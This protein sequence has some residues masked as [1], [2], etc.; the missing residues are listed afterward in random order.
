MVVSHFRVAESLSKDAGRG[1]VRLD[2]N[3]LERLGLEVGDVVAIVGKKKALA[4]VMPAFPDD[5]GSNSVQMDGILR[6]NTGVGLGE[7]VS[8]EKLSCSPA[9]LVSL[10]PALPKRFTAKEK[11]A[12]FLG[13]LLEG[14]PLLPNSLV[15]VNLLGA[16]R[17][18][19]VL[20]TDP[21][22]AVIVTAE[23]EIR[24]VGQGAGKGIK[25]SYEDIGGL[26]LEIQRVREMVELPLRY[27]ELFERLGIDAPKGILLHGPPGTGKT[28]IARAVAHET[29]AY[30]THVN[31]P[32]IVHKFYGE[33]EARLREIFENA[34]EKAPSII[35]LDEIDAIAPKREEVTGEVEKRIVAQLLALMDGL[36]SRGQVVVIGATNIPHSLDPALRRP[37]RF[38]RELEVRVPDRG[39]RLEILQIHTRGMPLQGDVDLEHL[40]EVTQGF[41]GADVEAL[42][43]EA[44]MAALRGVLPQIDYSSGEIPDEVLFGLRVT[45]DH[46]QSALRD[47]EPSAMREVFVEIPDVGWDDVGGLDEVKRQ[48]REAVEWPFTHQELFRLARA[49]APKGILLFGP[50][51]TGK[52]LVA[53]AIAGEA[54]VNFIPVRG[55][56][57]LSK[58]VGESEKGVREVFRKA[59]QAAPCIVF[60]DEIDALVSPRGRGDSQVTDRVLSQMLTEMD[61]IEELKGVMV[62]AATNRPDLLDPALLRPG[63]FD[64]LLELPLPDERARADIFRLHV[65]ARPL[66]T[67]VDLAALAGQAEGLSGADIRAVCQRAT[68]LAIREFVG[69][70]EPSST[71]PCE[72]RLRPDHFQDALQAV[73]RE[74]R[75]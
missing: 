26:G 27:P 35:F 42:C 66:A 48:L 15:R 19:T 67:G 51:G 39:G 57:L 21:K 31:G 29:K 22:G 63:R 61:G 43:R 65:K 53:K 28:L 68:M 52:T 25:V 23:T 72:M 59:R 2:P 74:R 64:L 37:G 45:M 24:L 3:D 4:R 73:K 13:R 38:D 62:L 6:E 54:R 33:S 46:F 7:Q 60:F 49:E 17:E 9:R 5:R 69:A 34:R 58:W 16:P 47:I 32:E 56:S 40:A 11:E 10:L 8:V 75:G 18:F 36:E 70:G 44:A 71:N 1:I 14:Y 41:V 55:P 12:L 20:E 30:F 50:P